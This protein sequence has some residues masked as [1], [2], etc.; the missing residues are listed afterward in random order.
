MKW[1]LLSPQSPAVCRSK[2][3]RY[4]DNY[5]NP[6]LP[7]IT[8]TPRQGEFFEVLLCYLGQDLELYLTRCYSISPDWSSCVLPCLRVHLINLRPIASLCGEW[9]NA[10]K[11]WIFVAFMDPHI[12][13]DTTQF[14]HTIKFFCRFFFVI[15]FCMVIES[16]KWNYRWLWRPR[17]RPC[18]GILPALRRAKNY[19]VAISHSQ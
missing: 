3:K 4:S 5:A 8:I 17:R 1:P 18:L 7:G 15:E 13:S 19:I 16:K 9:Y 2:F 6:S 10:F 12:T 11:D 14:E